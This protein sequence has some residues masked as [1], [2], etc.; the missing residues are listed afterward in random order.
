M[1]AGGQSDMKRK[2]RIILLV[3]IFIA[4]LF[5]GCN[6]SVEKEKESRI[7]ESE[8]VQSTAEKNS[9]KEVDIRATV[10]EEANAGYVL[11]ILSVESEVMRKFLEGKGEAAFTESFI[12]NCPKWDLD[13]YY[14]GTI[15]EIVL[16]YIRVF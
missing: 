14:E 16:G 1:Y 7:F 15:D 11:D 13:N 2:N 3:F 9:R 10:E 4:L 8:D 12:S 6:N 5:S